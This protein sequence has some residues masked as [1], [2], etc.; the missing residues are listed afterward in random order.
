M[1]TI[2]ECHCPDHWVPAMKYTDQFVVPGWHCAVGDFYLETEFFLHPE[3]Y[4]AVIVENSDESAG[5]E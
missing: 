3:K 4:G 5:G 2:T 1:A